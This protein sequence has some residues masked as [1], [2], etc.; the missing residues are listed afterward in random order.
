MATVGLNRTDALSILETSKF[1]FYLGGSRRMEQKQ[2]E[3]CKSQDLNDYLTE[4]V[5]I[6]ITAETDYDFYVTHDMDVEQ[7]LLDNGFT[8]TVSSIGAMNSHPD[9]LDSEAIRILE[10]DNVQVVL[11]LDAKFYHQVFESISTRFYYDNLWK[12]SPE[13]INVNNIQPIFNALFAT[14]HAFT[15]KEP[16]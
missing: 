2:I 7:F 10:R 15:T 5:P 8:D 11:R 13:I 3:A 1:R 14:A 4:W 12:S 6:V 16:Y 9:Y